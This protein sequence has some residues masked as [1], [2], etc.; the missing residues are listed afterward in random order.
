MVPHYTDGIRS[1]DW[2]MRYN[3][4]LLYTSGLGLPGDLSSSSRFVRVAFTKVNA[5]SGESEEESVSP[6]SYTHL[7]WS[8]VCLQI[9][10]L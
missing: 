10:H 2:F 1:V 4:C 7:Y 9:F 6:V 3:D 5:I 8:E